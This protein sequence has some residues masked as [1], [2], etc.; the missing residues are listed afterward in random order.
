MDKEPHLSLE[1]ARV[2]SRKMQEK[3]VQQAKEELT[4]MRIELIQ[5]PTQ[6]INMRVAAREPGVSL[7]NTDGVLTSIQESNPSAQ[8]G[9]LNNKGIL[10]IGGKE[11]DTKGGRINNIDFIQKLAQSNNKIGA[12]Y[13]IVQVGTEMNEFKE[14]VP[15][16]TAHEV[17][18][19][20]TQA[21]EDIKSRQEKLNRI[22]IVS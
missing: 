4:Q 18:N 22:G 5:S 17:H 6:S 20:T 7:Q 11:F 21:S 13:M 8:I 16:Y 1:E 3:V 2:L 9:I 12:S 19:N 15:V 10:T 14:V